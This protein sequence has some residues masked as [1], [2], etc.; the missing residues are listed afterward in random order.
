MDKKGYL[1]DLARRPVNNL[2][3]IGDFKK[4]R[5]IMKSVINTN[6]KN[7]DG[8]IA[9]ARIEELDGNIKAARNILSQ[10]LSH[11]ETS[12][13]LWIETVRIEHPEK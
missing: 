11:C 5:A 13:D 6:P 7:P 10:G 1:T 2:A 8:W 4:A 3:D 9:A 12:D